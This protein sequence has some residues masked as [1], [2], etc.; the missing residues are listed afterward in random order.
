MPQPIERI[1]EKVMPFVDELGRRQRA[2]MRLVE[3]RLHQVGVEVGGAAVGL[4]A[5]GSAA[6]V[7]IEFF[8]HDQRACQN[9]ARRVT[10]GVGKCGAPVIERLRRPKA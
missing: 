7:G 8:A 6:A 4:D 3:Q 5:V 9:T 10:P 1:N 2:E